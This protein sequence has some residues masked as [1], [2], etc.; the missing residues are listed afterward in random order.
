MLVLHQ[1]IH[2]LINLRLSTSQHGLWM[3]EP[4]ITNH[5]PEYRDVCL[6]RPPSAKTV[7]LFAVC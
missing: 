1:L 4:D 5:N 3:I 7:L 6:A 2:K